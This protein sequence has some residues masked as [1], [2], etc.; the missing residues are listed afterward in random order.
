[1]LTAKRGARAFGSAA[2]L[3]HYNWLSGGP[4]SSAE[5][6]AR[7]WYGLRTAPPWRLED[8]IATEQIIRAKVT[9]GVAKQFGRPHNH[10]G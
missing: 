5:A 10:K 3:F 6:G 1:M 9:A 2:A 8:A 4:Q 7:S